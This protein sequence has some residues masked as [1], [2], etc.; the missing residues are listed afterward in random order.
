VSTGARP[1]SGSDRKVSTS[2]TRPRT[3]AKALAV[4]AALA[5]FAAGCTGG[6]GDNT[7]YQPGN[8]GLTEVRNPSAAKGGELRLVN[9]SDIDSLDPARAYYGYVHNMMRLYTRTLVTFDAKPGEAGKKVVPDLAT[10]L[11][12]S[13]NGNR[14]WTYT[15]KDGVKFEDG[16]PITS[17]D[18]KYG[19]ERNF[20]VDV[21]GGNHP[22]YLQTYLQDKNSPYPGPYKD[23]DPQKLGLKSVVTP[24]DKTIVFN[25]NTAV[26]DFPYVLQ[27]PNASPVPRAKDT[28]AAYQNKPVASGPYRI[29][30]YQKG[31]Q[32]IFVR[33]P[34]WDAKTDSVRK[35][36]PDRIT[37][38]GGL[39]AEDVDAR[40]LAGEADVFAGMSGV[41]VST[42]SR[43]LKNKDQAAQADNPVTGA[44]RY[45]GLNS[46]VPPL[47]NVE[48]RNAIIYAANLNTLQRSRGGIYGGDIATSMYPPSL[49][50]YESYDP[51]GL[52]QN[53][54]GQVQKAK[55]AL[56]KCG[57]PNGFA[58]N[59]ASPDKGKGPP[60]AE[61][62]QAALKQVG[63]NATIAK[64]S[65]ASYYV[66]FA[67]SPANVHGKKLGIL[68]GGWSSDYPA[69]AGF[70][71]PIVDG[72]SIAPQGNSNIAE[73]NSPQVNAAV[74]SALAAPTVDASLVHWR[75]VDK[76]VMDEARFLPFLVDKALMY[77]NP[78]V[79]NLYVTGGW[80][81]YD[82]ASMGVGG[83]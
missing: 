2:V 31:K 76:L 72:R 36:L 50:G 24:D 49:V 34:N 44:I 21:L 5:T 57:Q 12:R 62:L 38:T 30:K 53:P 56:K 27:L 19:I 47:D 80:G 69:P 14:T 61:A 1:G 43:L 11:G 81:Q 60:A 68:M 16:T 13:S 63:I 9:S 35:A 83:K 28:G 40:L 64:A 17:R 77:A 42:Q 82:F 74:D 18:V 32:I 46:H 73:I 3:A 55:D 25:L 71:P 23:K 41:Q 59:I 45:Y 52:K 10:D 70:F 48:C 67:G 66:T 51:F 20:A 6:G 22:P 29:E 54:A 39:S 8:K 37:Y 75:Q 65:E 4:L 78:R 79:T 58:V 26:P 7:E 33:N 15:L